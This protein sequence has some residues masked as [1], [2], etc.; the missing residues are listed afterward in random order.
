[1]S[2]WQPIETAP[3]DGEFIL[4]GW[5][6]LPDYEDL[7][8]AITFWID[9]PFVNGTGWSGVFKEPTHWRPL[10]KPPKRKKLRS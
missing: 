8:I 9:E 10:P 7:R 3:K 1:M 2:K 4:V 6:N 5:D